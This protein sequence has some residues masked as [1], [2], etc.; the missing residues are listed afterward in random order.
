MDGFM[1]WFFAFMTTMLRAV[2]GSI[3]GFFGGGAANCFCM[4]DFFRMT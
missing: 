2:W 3:S 4:I 1:N